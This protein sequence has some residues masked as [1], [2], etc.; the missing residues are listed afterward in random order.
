MS[1]AGP[2]RG[3]VR[4]QP[5]FAEEDAAAYGGA[6]VTFAPGARSAWHAHPAGQ[7]LIVTGGQAAPVG[8]GRRRGPLVIGEDVLDRRH[9]SRRHRLDPARPVAPVRR[10]PDHFMTPLAMWDGLADG[11]EGSETERGERVTDADC[12]V[13]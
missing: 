10:R 1:P 4:V 11:Q 6:Y 3:D 8:V 2:A 9:P 7:R 12:T 13:L 5:L